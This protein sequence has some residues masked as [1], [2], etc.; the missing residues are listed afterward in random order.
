MYETHQGC[1]RYGT[2]E[3]PPASMNGAGYCTATRR[4]MRVGFLPVGPLQAG[5]GTARFGHFP[6]TDYLLLSQ[7]ERGREQYSS[8]RNRAYPC[9]RAPKTATRDACE[10]GVDQHIVRRREGV[11]SA[12]SCAS[13]M[14]SLYGFV[15]YTKHII[16]SS[17]PRSRD[18]GTMPPPM[19]LGAFK[20]FPPS[21][22]SF[23]KLLVFV[24][25]ESCVRRCRLSSSGW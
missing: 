15:T 16:T 9:L 6:V 19:V 20:G 3:D 24:A 11:I 18:G 21:T 8:R 14:G 13:N 7:A 22:A 17:W 1:R 12:W 5:W 2:P 25:S 4:Y 23:A 10:E